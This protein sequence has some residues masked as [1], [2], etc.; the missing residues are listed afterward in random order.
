MKNE[1]KHLVVLIPG[2]AADEDD[3]TCLPAQQ[4]FM[5]SLRRIYPGLKVSV[6]AFQYPFTAREYSWNGID[7][8]PLNGRN[9][10]GARRLITWYRAWKLMKRLKKDGHVI[11]LLSF[12]CSD[13]A[14]VAKKFATKNKMKHY[15]WVLGQDAKKENGFV[16]RIK[17]KASELI[18]MSDF[19]KKEF[20]KN[21][22]ID[23]AYV[24]PNAIDTSVFSGTTNDRTIDLIG[25]GSLIRLKR[26][27]IFI[28]VLGKLVHKFP[29]LRS[30]ICGKGPEHE[31]LQHLINELGLK[32]H[33][34]LVGEKSHHEVL[35]C[36][37]ESKIL[38]HP[39]SYEGY[40]GACAEALYA[41]AHVVSFCSPSSTSIEHW[42]VVQTTEEMTIRINE[43]LSDPLLDHKRVL[44][45]SIDESTRAIMSLYN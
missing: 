1:H 42:H 44:T 18:A 4:A 5:K 15:C 29:S 33:V 24:V 16:N 21:H 43:L 23:P 14:L 26:Y 19:L 28:E 34:Q 10:G 7:V 32:A 36:L 45:Q 31:K 9:K 12:W 40:S 3:S 27:E 25:V 39:S 13:C 30:L 6:I 41:G 37:Q 2:F 35:Q 22:G 17:P 11:G 20:H 38:V 8:F